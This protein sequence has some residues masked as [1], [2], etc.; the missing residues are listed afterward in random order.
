MSLDAGALRN[1]ER[2]RLRSLVET[3]M[4]VAGDLHADEYQLITP[5]GRALSKAEYLDSVAAGELRY[6]VFEPIAQVAVG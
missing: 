1:V 3:D 5:R 2:A 6:R 4:D